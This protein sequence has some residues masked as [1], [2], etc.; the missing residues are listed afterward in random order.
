MLGVAQSGIEECAY[1]FLFTAI[2]DLTTWT[3]LLNCGV[4]IMARS[5]GVIVKIVLELDSHVTE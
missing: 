4:I 3:V 1:N 2:L 5:S